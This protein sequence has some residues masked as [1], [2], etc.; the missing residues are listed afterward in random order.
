MRSSGLKYFSEERQGCLRNSWGFDRILEVRIGATQQQG[1]LRSKILAFWPYFPTIS[2][3]YWVV[4]TRTI[5]VALVTILF[6]NYKYNEIEVFEKG[7]Q[8]S[9]TGILVTSIFMWKYL[10]KDAQIVLISVFGF[11]LVNLDNRLTINI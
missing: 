6:L 11:Y 8:M 4:E 3:L 7:Y 1:G 2:S 9:I 10:W 5:L